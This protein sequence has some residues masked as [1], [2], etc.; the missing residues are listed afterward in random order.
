[1]LRRV[2]GSDGEPGRD[3]AGFEASGFTVRVLGRDRVKI[4]E[5]CSQAVMESVH[6]VAGLRSLS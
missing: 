3:V 2:W 4:V 6:N 5:Y 1:M